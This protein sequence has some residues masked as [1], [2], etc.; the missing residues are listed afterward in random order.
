VTAERPERCEGD[1]CV[2]LLDDEHAI[3]LAEKLARK[4][5]RAIVVID[6]NG[7]EICVAPAPRELDS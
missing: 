5:N 4:L 2:E 1:I 6:T 3:A 7:N